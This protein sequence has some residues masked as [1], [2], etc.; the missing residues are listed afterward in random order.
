[1]SDNATQ[2][3]AQTNIQLFNQMRELGYSVA[4]LRLI[5][6]TYDLAVSLFSALFRASGKPFLA[7]LVGT[8]SILAS[9]R[10]PIEIVAAGLLHAAYVGGDFGSGVTGIT[11]SKRAEVQ[12][13]VG[14]SVESY[15]VAYTQT[16]WN[17]DVPQLVATQCHTLDYIGRGVTLIRLA[18]E[19]EEYLD[20]GVLYCGAEKRRATEYVGAAGE[21]MMHIARQ[22]GVPKLADHFRVA[23]AAIAA[24]PPVPAS[25]HDHAYV[26]PPRSYRRMMELLAA[27]IARSAA[28]DV[29]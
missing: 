22:L 23:F 4:D 5:G 29:A 24:A 13:V 7:H 11:G 19:L 2:S 17:R 26:V 14:D 15:V 10:E 6:A 9:L 18:N 25:S 8:A 12:R 21:A 28:P 16:T 27:R 20:L 1:M 3:F